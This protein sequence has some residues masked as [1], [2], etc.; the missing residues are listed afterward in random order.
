MRLNSSFL[1]V[2][3][4][5]YLPQLPDTYT[6]NGHR[7]T[8]QGLKPFIQF[9]YWSKGF[10]LSCVPLVSIYYH[11]MIQKSRKIFIFFFVKIYK[12]KILFLCNM[13]IF[14]IVP[15]MNKFPFLFV[16]GGHPIKALEAPINGE[17][18]DG[19]FFRSNLESLADRHG[20]P[21]KARKADPGGVLGKS[22]CNIPPSA[23]PGNKSPRNIFL[24]S[25]LLQ[26]KI[27][28]LIPPGVCFKFWNLTSPQF[29]AIIYT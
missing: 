26:T 29:H 2:K 21:Q 10:A 25:S 18:F 12:V 28:N 16:Y 17:K 11:S 13:Y 1:S 14:T 19:I 22:P 7:T 6:H 27:F 3:L 5:C 20:K 24:K 9:C 15:V 23:R 8:P 4:P